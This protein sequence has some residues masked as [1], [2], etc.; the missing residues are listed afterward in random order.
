MPSELIKKTNYSLYFVRFFTEDILKIINSLD[1]SK[2]HGHDAISIRM[3]KISDSSVCRPLQIIYKCFL[4]RRKLPQERKK[5]NVV[6][7]HDFDEHIKRIFDKTSKSISLIRQLR[8]FLP[9]PSLLQI[10]KSF[11]RPHL[12]YGDIIC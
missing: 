1:S 10:Y 11:V 3:L 7:V 9:R 2:A 6:P 5:A 4:N 8:N 12:D